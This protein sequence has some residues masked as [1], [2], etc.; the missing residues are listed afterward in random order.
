MSGDLVGR[1]VSR[2]VVDIGDRV[3][4]RIDHASHRLNYIVV[5]RLSGHRAISAIPADRCVDQRCISFYALVWVEADTGGLS[6][7]HV[8]NNDISLVCELLQNLAPEI[9]STINSDSSFPAVG[10]VKVGSHLVAN[11]ASSSSEIWRCRRF[12]FDDLSTQVS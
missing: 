8:L 9:M 6:G 1:K 7:P 4:L 3:P 12:H 5:Y 2:Q 11:R 10:V